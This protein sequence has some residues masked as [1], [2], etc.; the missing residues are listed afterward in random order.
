M[1]K[2][3]SNHGR[4]L[5][6]AEPEAS[7][8]PEEMRPPRPSRSDG[9]IPACPLAP[10][11]HVRLG[12]PIRVRLRSRSLPGLLGWPRLRLG[13]DSDGP[14]RMARVIRLGWPRLRSRPPEPRQGSWPIGS[15]P[16]AE[17]WSN[18]G[19][20]TAEPWSNHGQTRARGPSAAGRRAG[21][22]LSP[23]PLSLSPPLP[24]PSPRA[25]APTP[26][27]TTHIF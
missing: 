15:G 5:P 9:P 6:R 20:T 13:C 2:P 21:L 12:W 7:G 14:S 25:R 1:V 23:F 22:S 24:T 27:R 18:H 26:H 8:E 10:T 11:P 4:T 3:W 17:P 16:S 19:Q